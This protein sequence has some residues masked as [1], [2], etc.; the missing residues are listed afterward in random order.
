MGLDLGEQT[1][2]KKE[3]ETALPPLEKDTKLKS[4]EFLQGSFNFKNMT[5]AKV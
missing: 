2:E 1:D 5:A 3:K 4:D